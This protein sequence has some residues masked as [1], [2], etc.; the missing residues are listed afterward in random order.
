M[1]FSYYLPVLP[2]AGADQKWL[3]SATPL[4]VLRIQIRQKTNLCCQIRI[5]INTYPDSDPAIGL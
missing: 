3:G 2:T 1:T 5:R 4:T